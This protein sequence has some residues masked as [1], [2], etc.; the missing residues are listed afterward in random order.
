MSGVGRNGPSSCTY[1][2]RLADSGSGVVG[3]GTDEAIVRGDPETAAKRYQASYVGPDLAR[4]LAPETSTSKAD[5]EGWLSQE[6]RLIER[7]EWTAPALRKARAEHD[8]TQTL[9]TYTETWLPERTAVRSLKPKTVSE[10]QRYL[11]RLIFPSLGDLRLKDVTPATIRAWIGKLNPK[12]P[13]INEHAYALLKTIFAT[14]VQDELLDRN[15]CR[16]RMRKPV[17]KIG[18]PASLDELALLVGDARAAEVDDRTGC[19][20]RVAVRRGRRAAS[21]RR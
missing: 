4:H 5:A 9:R 8:A 6:R 11:D 14:A 18:E 10:Y 12:T 3:Y 13:R 7:D 17:R 21:R 20:V 2:A 16:E 19:L 15:P 1:V